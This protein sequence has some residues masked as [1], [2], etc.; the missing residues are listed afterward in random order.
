MH[1]LNITCPL[2]HQH[3]DFM[4]TGVL[5]LTCYILLAFKKPKSIQV[6]IRATSISNMKE[7][8]RLKKHKAC[9]VQNALVKT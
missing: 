1:Y 5:R 6:T 7:D 8:C 2:G 4:A 3:N 9:S